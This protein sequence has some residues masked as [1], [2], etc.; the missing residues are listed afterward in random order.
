[1]QNKKIENTVIIMVIFISKI[2]NMIN[3]IKKMDT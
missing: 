3:T 1:M 2:A